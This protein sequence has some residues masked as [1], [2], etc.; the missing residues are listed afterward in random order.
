M[1][2]AR[3][4]PPYHRLQ[5]LLMNMIGNAPTVKIVRNAVL[6]IFLSSCAAAVAT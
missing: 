4:I 6:T 2:L 1:F 3:D 5:L